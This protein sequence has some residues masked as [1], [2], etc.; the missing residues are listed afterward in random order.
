MDPATIIQE[1]DALGFKA[2]Q[3]T[4]SEA[5]APTKV[6]KGP[7]A[8]SPLVEELLQQAR[9]ESKP[10]VLE[11]SGRFCPACKRLENETL[12]D[13]RVQAALEKVIFRKIMVEENR[14]AAT[15]FDIHAIP[16][17]RFLT[18]DGEVVAKD[19]GVISVETMLAHLQKL[20][21]KE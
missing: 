17:L 4:E 6:T 10:L 20:G 12:E 16:Q 8:K 19:K 9:R 11:F 3:L 7:E 21:G 2:K 15:R 13:P 14:A 1:I 18:P 5:T